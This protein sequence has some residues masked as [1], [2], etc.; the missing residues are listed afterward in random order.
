[1]KTLNRVKSKKKFNITFSGL[2]SSHVKSC[3][4]TEKAGISPL[5]FPFIKA[6][7]LVKVGDTVHQGAPLFFDKKNPSVY[8]HSPVSGTVASIQYGPQRHL[9]LIEIDVDKTAMP[10][11]FNTVDASS[12]DATSLKNALLERGLWPAFRQLP[13]HNIP[14]PEETPPALIVSFSNPEPFHPRLSTVIDDVED[15]LARGIEALSHLTSSIIVLADAN[16]SINLDRFA[17]LAQVV[18]VDGDFSDCSPASVNFRLKDDVKYNQSWYL[19]WQDVLKMARTFQSGTYYNQKLICVGGKQPEDNHHYW[20]TE[21]AP[22]SSIVTKH[23][24][25]DRLIFG[26]LLTG[27]HSP[28]DTYLPIASDAINIVDNAPKTEFVSF[29]Q[30]GFDKPSFT[31]AYVSG[32]LNA[33]RAIIPTTALNGSIRDCVSCGYCEAVCPV[34]ALPQQILRNVEGQDVEASFR[35]GLLDC[36]NC[37]VCTYVCPS[38]IDLSSTFMQAKSQLFEEV[39]AE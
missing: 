15:D 5:N 33:F 1:M 30:P 10:V 38:K 17:P 31:N 39:N 7:V 9:H 3:L 24:A 22:V 19:D 8:F 32:F 6:K 20:V 2:P 27:I 26:G 21:G 18:R 12:L 23:V 4:S 25:S 34:D 29:M 16:E 11:T 14:K 36:S 35:F 13:F 37:G 28:Q